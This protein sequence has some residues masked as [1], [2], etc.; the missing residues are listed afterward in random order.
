[1]GIRITLDALLAHQETNKVKEAYNRATYKEQMRNLIQ[2][3][4][5]WLDNIK[6]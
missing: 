3:Y 5:N 1:M 6:K 4:A 2:W